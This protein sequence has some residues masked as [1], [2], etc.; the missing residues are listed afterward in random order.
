M[1]YKLF[2]DDCLNILGDIPENSVDFILTDP[3]YGINFQSC[4]IKDKSKRKP[5]TINDGKPFID[6]IPFLKKIIKPTGCMMIFT[7]WDVQNVFMNAMQENGLK[8]KSIIIWDKIK[9]AWVI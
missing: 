8:I 2:N 4:R 1:A 5:K 6:F 7:R 3:P 9:H